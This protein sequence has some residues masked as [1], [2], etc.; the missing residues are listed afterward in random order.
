LFEERE[1]H[2]S[3]QK[4]ILDGQNVNLID[5]NES[6]DNS[7][8]KLLMD[9]KSYPTLKDLSFFRFSSKIEQIMI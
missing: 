6:A 1:K 4:S 7:Q 3:S 9:Q 5:L 2:I 8:L